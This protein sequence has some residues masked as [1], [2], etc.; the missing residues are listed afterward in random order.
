MY[1]W[2]VMKSAGQWGGCF[3]WPGQPWQ[4]PSDRSWSLCVA[5]RVP[6]CLP[7]AAATCWRQTRPGCTHLPSTLSYQ[8]SGSISKPS[9]FQY[10]YLDVLT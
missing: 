9:Y 3:K 8:Y 4:T 6:R 7:T 10:A 1:L 2:T 5:W